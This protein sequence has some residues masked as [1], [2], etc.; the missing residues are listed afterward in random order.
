[1]FTIT[2]SIENKALE[3]ECAY[4]KDSDLHGLEQYA[5]SFADRLRTYELIRDN[6]DQIVHDSL[7]LLERDYP[8]LIKKRGDRCKYDMNEVLRYMASS[9]LRND[10]QY[11]RDKMTDWLGTILVSY[12]VTTECAKG[13][14]YMYEVMSRVLP[15][16]HAVMVRPY[17]DILVTTLTDNY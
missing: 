1:M 7:G 3:L 16:K 4:L 12:Q 2:P 9:I 13:Y 8:A 15:A 14:T 5:Q 6:A 10:E 11:F 17:T